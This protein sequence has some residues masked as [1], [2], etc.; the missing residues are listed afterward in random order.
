MATD[1]PPAD[2]IAY[3]PRGMRREVAARYLSI[4]IAQ[5]KKLVAVGELPKPV[6][7]GGMAIWD[8]LELDSA[9]EDWKDKQT[10]ECNTFDATLGRP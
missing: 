6:K 5:F 7:V 4:S 10:A 2:A 1:E 9:F 3:P 8:R